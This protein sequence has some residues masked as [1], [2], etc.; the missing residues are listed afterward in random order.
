VDKEASELMGEAVVAG[1]QL[2][3]PELV[4]STIARGALRGGLF[5]ELA[6]SLV[7][8][9]KEVKSTLPGGHKGACYMA[10]GAEKVGFFTVKQGI[11]KNSPGELLVEHP[12]SDVAC[13]EIEKGVMPTA[14]ILLQD[15]TY[16]SLKCARAN[17][18]SLKKVQE[19]LST[20][21]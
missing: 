9:G 19:L 18:N 21:G 7:S 6:G 15:G 20:P 14:H 5:G 12:R 16:Y 4:K 1:V 2:E 17:L 3:A 10:V 13:V 11:F 8:A